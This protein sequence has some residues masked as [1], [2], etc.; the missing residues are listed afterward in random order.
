MVRNIRI[1]KYYYNGGVDYDRNDSNNG[2]H[3]NKSFSFNFPTNNNKNTVIETKLDP[4]DYQEMTE[5]VS[6]DSIN[7]KWFVNLSQSQIPY[8]VQSLLQ[9]GQNFSLPPTNNKHNIIQL[10]KNIENNIINLHLDIQT[11]VRNRS[12]PFIHNLLSRSSNVNPTDTKLLD[13]LK[14]TNKFIKDNPNIIYTRADKG[15]ITVA[16]DNNE[17]VDT[18]ENI[19]SDTETYTKINKDP[20][21][22][23][24]NQTRELLT[25]WRNKEYITNTTYNNIYNSD[26]NLPR[27]YGLPKIH[28]PLELLFHQ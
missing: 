22:K 18:I 25:R 15:N 2:H 11:K 16:L 27:A 24:T 12:I 9:L 10:V 19:L 20:T 1:I 8:N 28:K 4:R 3:T 17:Y 21:K 14:I 6:L 5:I 26:G 23:L 7:N 13:R